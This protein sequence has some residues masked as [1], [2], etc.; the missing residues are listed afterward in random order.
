MSQIM[1]TEFNSWLW[2]VFE[3]GADKKGSFSPSLYGWRTNGDFGLVLLSTNRYPTF[4]A[5]KLMRAFARSGDTILDVT[6]GDP[7]LTV[8]ASQETNGTLN[9]LA[10]NKDRTNTGMKTI[11][12]AGFS[13]DANATI[14]SYGIA[15]DE[16]ARTNAPFAKQNIAT[17]QMVVSHGS[18]GYS[19]GPYSMTLFSLTPSGPPLIV[20]RPVSDTLVISWPY[21]STGWT[22]EQS[23]DLVNGTWTAPAGTIQNDGTNNFIN[24]SPSADNLFFRLNKP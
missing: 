4:Y 13:P 24:I 5:F 11:N 20:S 1:K 19:F 23:T 18:F 12:L 15:Q 6:S 7:F 8:Y 21:P 2:W 3:S 9:I 10:I 17:N 16:A 22:L 14:R